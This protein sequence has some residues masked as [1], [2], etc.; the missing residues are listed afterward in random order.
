[1]LLE[2]VDAVA[3]ADNQGR[4]AVPFRN[5]Y[6]VHGPGELCLRLTWRATG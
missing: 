3:F 1:M 4:A 2:R 6:A 5:Y